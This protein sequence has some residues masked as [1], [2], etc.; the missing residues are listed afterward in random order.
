MAWGMTSAHGSR[1]IVVLFFTL[2]F[3]LALS[4][5]CT[6]NVDAAL[7]NLTRSGCTTARPSPCQRS[8]YRNAAS[9]GIVQPSSLCTLYNPESQYEEK[10]P[11]LAP[12]RLA[13]KG[14]IDED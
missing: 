1:A 10:S 8:C 13:I 3:W 4:K 12:V 7:G 5:L 11:D 2:D 6:C 9:V 14:Q